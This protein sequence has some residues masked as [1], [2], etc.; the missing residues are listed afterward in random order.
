MAS[1][2]RA[3]YFWIIPSKNN[4]D[5]ELKLKFSRQ[6]KE[7][8][9]GVEMIVD[10]AHFFSQRFFTNGEVSKTDR[11]VPVERHSI[12]KIEKLFE[13]AS[14]IVV[15]NETQ[16]LYFAEILNGNKKIY[17]IPQV[18]KIMDLGLPRERRRHICVFGTNDFN[19]HTGETMYSPDI[20]FDS[21][22][23]SNSS[24][25]F[26]LIF[27]DLCA[28]KY[29]PESGWF[30]IIAARKHLLTILSNYKLCIIP[31]GCTTPAIEMFNI[32]AA[33]GVPIVASKTAAEE[34]P[35]NNGNECFIADSPEE[36][37]DKCNQ[38]LLDPIAWHNFKIKS[39]LMIAE[40]NSPLTVAKKMST[41]FLE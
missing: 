21:I 10:T 27:D 39:Q 14:K 40:N 26:R 25:N 11:G 13:L 12:E 9:P 32:A 18:Y 22:R 19:Y 2:N 5:F 3:D 24:F 4:N 28:G 7:K 31:I 33:A 35:V 38:C 41:L 20:I 15:S 29:T 30:K 37:A 8:T 23:V 1:E 16:K 6:L 34:Y 17:D 36:F